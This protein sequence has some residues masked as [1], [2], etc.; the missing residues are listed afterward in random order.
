MPTIYPW[1]EESKRILKR[2]SQYGRTNSDNTHLPRM[3]GTKYKNILDDGLL[4]IA[5]TRYGKR[6]DKVLFQTPE[7]VR[8]F[9]ELDQIGRPLFKFKR[10]RF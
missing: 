10:I 9:E 2:L 7:D 3:F 8:I 6:K 4:D 5:T 1:D